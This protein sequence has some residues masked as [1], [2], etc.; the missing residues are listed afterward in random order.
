MNLNR[1]EKE[2]LLTTFVGHVADLREQQQ[3]AYRLLGCDGSLMQAIYRVEYDAMVA[4]A[5]LIGDAGD[6]LDWF[7]NENECGA[8]GYEAKRAEWETAR[9]IRTVSDL[10]DILE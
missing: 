1:D 6:W 9:P 10:L 7:I 5:R 8:K 4:I 2:R 3:I